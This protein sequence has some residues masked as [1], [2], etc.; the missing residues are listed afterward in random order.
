M[1]TRLKL[2]ATT[3]NLFHSLEESIWIQS[4]TLW[5]CPRWPIVSAHCWV[6]RLPMRPLPEHNQTAV[7]PNPAARLLRLRWRQP[8]R[9]IRAKVEIV[10]EFGRKVA[11]IEL[12]TKRRTAPRRQRSTESN[13]CVRPWP[14]QSHIRS[15]DRS[16]FA[17][18]IPP[19][20]RIE[21][22][23][24]GRELLWCDFPYALELDFCMRSTRKSSVA[25]AQA[26]EFVGW[27]NTWRVGKENERRCYFIQM[28]A[29]NFLNSDLFA[30]VHL[31]PHGDG[32]SV[33]IDDRQR[34]LIDGQCKWWR[35]RSIWHDADC[36]TLSVVD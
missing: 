31:C 1:I 26:P 7:H 17:I 4:R 5:T 11:S 34:T 14:T 8:R 29:N 9:R 24:R 20:H 3:K 18:G 33:L 15:E 32:G 30:F 19:D 16:R 21:W 23:G 6:F 2:E 25:P 13:C 36:A 35:N 12:W 28:E 22:R 10:F 27:E